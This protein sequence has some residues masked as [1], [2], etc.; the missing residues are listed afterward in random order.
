MVSLSLRLERPE[1]LGMLR[2]MLRQVIEFVGLSGDEADDLVLA[3]HEIAA[4][5]LVHGQP[6]AEVTIQANV[7]T[8]AVQVT[9]RGQGFGLGEPADHWV[10]PQAESGRGLWL[11]EQI[12][13][14]LR[15]SRASGTCTVA[16]SLHVTTRPRRT[17]GPEGSRRSG[18]SARRRR[19]K[20]EGL[21][22]EAGDR[23][24]SR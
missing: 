7:G 20:P 19:R 15:V 5:A 18:E 3:T 2:S 11:A 10:D 24:R 16:A 12:L 23:A 8:M 13:G 21:P 17:A 14:G 6:P 4:N 1:Q 22:T 9:D